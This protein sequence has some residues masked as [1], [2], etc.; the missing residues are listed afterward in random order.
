MKPINLLRKRNQ[1]VELRNL[2]VPAAE[3]ITKVKHRTIKIMK[4]GNNI[5]QT[6]RK[7]I[8]EQRLMGMM[9]LL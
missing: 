6:N 5:I 1:D 8:N 2:K 3:T 7:N 4:M 9:F